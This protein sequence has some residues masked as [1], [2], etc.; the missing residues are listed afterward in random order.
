MKAVVAQPPRAAGISVATW[1]WKSVR[2]FVADRFGKRLSARSC[3]RY[4]HRLFK[5]DGTT[6]GAYVLGL[7]LVRAEQMLGDPRCADL[8][9]SA[10][11]YDAGFGDLSYFYRSFRRRFGATPSDLRAAAARR[12]AE[13]RTSK[14]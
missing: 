6:F 3:L 7:R 1:S 11:G 8:S 14:R 5:E 2:Q 4:L 13:T 12:N 10:I 9:I